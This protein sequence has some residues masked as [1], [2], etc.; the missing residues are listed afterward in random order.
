PRSGSNRA[1]G[2]A[3]YYLRGSDFAARPPFIPFK[4]QSEQH[5]SDGTLGGPIKKD[6]IHYFLGFDQHI[7]HV[8]AVVEFAN[9]TTTLTPAPADYEASDQALVFDAAAQL[10]QLAGT[11]RTGLLGNAAF[12]KL[13]F[14]LNQ[15][16]R[17]TLRFN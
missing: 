7:F 9:A 4:P 10:S 5:Q 3:F 14:Q 12:G 11:Y 13:D 16:E 8:P 15:N 6:K 2:T 17:L 1:H